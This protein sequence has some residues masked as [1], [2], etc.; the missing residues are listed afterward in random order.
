MPRKFGLLVAT[1]AV[2]LVAGEAVADGG[3]AL[4]Q[5]RKSDRCTLTDGVDGKTNQGE[6]KLQGG[7]A[8]SASGTIR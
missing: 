8:E 3:K 7:I 1:L 2:L 6:G 4:P 5:F